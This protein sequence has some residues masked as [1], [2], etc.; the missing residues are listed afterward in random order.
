MDKKPIVITIEGPAKSGKTTLAAII[1]RALRH[2]KVDLK[3]YD[4]EPMN[5]E[6]YE[7]VNQES[8]SRLTRFREHYRVE[9]RVRSNYRPQGRPNLRVVRTDA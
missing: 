3:I 5:Q 4:Q 9:I 1:A 8:G 2:F 6:I 7:K